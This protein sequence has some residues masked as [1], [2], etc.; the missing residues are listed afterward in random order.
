[1]QLKLALPFGNTN[2]LLTNALGSKVTSR[3][4]RKNLDAI[5]YLA[6]GAMNDRR[7]VNEAIVHTVQNKTC[8]IL[9]SS[10]TD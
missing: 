1:M 7:S 6:R 4:G 5:F 3:L 10:V 8:E 2:T 9:C